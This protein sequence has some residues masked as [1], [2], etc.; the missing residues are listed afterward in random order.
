ALGGWEVSGIGTFTDGQPFTARLGSERSRNGGG[1]R[2]DR[3]D[4]KPG[5]NNNPILGTVD[6]WYDPS[7]F[8]LPAI[9]TY[10]NLG[11]DTLLG[12]ARRTVDLSLTKKFALR[13]TADLQFRAELFNILN[14][15]NFGLPQNVPLTSSGAI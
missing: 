3:P 12:P 15:A 5:A 7:V 6:R 11:R 4:L 14:H 8:A 2:A 10:G 9:G 13:E 1:G